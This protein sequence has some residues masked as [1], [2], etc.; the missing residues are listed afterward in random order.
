MIAERIYISEIQS[1]LPYK[2]RRSVRKWCSNNH[3]LILSDIGSNKQYALRVEYE[4][5][6]CRNY[7]IHQESINSS[8]TYFSKSSKTEKGNEYI[9]LGR[10]EENFL[11]H[12]LNL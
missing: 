5:A 6:K 11:N 10:N 3:V 7:P 1:E 2:D 4:N 12:L 9:P 8:M